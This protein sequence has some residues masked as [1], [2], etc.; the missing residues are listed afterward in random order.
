[1]NI[2]AGI[3][4]NILSQ[5]AQSVICAAVR[6]EGLPHDSLPLPA[7]RLATWTLAPD[8][9]YREARWT[10]CFAEQ[11][12]GEEISVETQPEHFRTDTM[13]P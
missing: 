11:E 10:A 8:P 1:M 12:A 5:A 6:K 2:D 9:Q 13:R 3:V 7:V 4:A